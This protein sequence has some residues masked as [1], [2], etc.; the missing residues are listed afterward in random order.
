MPLPLMVGL[1]V[2]LAI[3][4]SSYAV[5]PV[6]MARGIRTV[7]LLCVAVFCMFGFLASFEVP[8]IAWKVVYAGL[9]AIAVSGAALPWL[10]S[11]SLKAVNPP[12]NRDSL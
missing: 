4:F 6:V 7:Q 2:L 12:V 9:G 8:G 5:K 3:F 10:F 1:L 11:K